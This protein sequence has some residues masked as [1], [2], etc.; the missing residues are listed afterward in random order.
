MPVLSVTTFKYSAFCIFE[1]NFNH[2][3]IVKIVT[4]TQFQ[5]LLKSSA[6]TVE[7]SAHI[8]KINSPNLPTLPNPQIY[9]T[10]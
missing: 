10:W 3:N 8:A 9:T 5:Y 4:L 6:I 2:C 1:Y 7:M